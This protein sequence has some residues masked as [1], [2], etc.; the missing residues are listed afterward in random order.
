M[1][2]MLDM[3]PADIAATLGREPGSV[4]A[5]QHR[6]LRALERRVVALGREPRPGPKAR[7]SRWP[8]RAPV[9]RER[10]FA[11]FK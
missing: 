9:L 7:M 10:R 2:Y 4:R 1:R 11:L 3:S 8:K 5:L 6:A